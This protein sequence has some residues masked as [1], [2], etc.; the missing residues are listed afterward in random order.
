MNIDRD[1][2]RNQNIQ[3]VNDFDHKYINKYRRKS[4]INYDFLY[5][6]DDI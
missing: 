3:H 2:D 1:Y 6:G 5:K 4:R